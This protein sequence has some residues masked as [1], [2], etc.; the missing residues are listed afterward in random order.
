MTRFNAERGDYGEGDVEEL[1]AER[2]ALANKFEE[3]CFTRKMP[4]GRVL[5]IKGWPLIGGGFVSAHIDVTERHRMIENLRRKNEEAQKTARDLK[6]AQQAQE[7][8]Y[9]HLV[10]SINS[11]NNG[12]AIWDR[13]GF[14]VLANDAFRRFHSSIAGAIR[15][16]LQIEHMLRLGCEAKIWAVSGGKCEAWIEACLKFHRSTGSSEEELV[17]TDGTQLVVTSQHL[18]NG[19]VITTLIDVTAQRERER[20]L[21]RTKEAL[22]HIAYFDAL[23]TLPNRA[24]CQQDL[25]ALFANQ[26]DHDRFS[27]IL[28]DLDKFKRVNDTLG[29]AS[30]DELLKTLGSRLNFLGT[31]VP[32]FKPYRWGGDEF[33]AIVEGIHENELESLCQELTDLI[34]IPLTLEGPNPTTLWPTVS[35]GIASYPGDATDLEAL[36]IYADLALYKTKEMGRDGYQFFSAE[37]KEKIDEDSRIEVDVRSALKLDQFELY[38]QPQISTVD[39]SISGV[40]AL[41]RWNH[42]E[43]GQLPPGLFM[44]VVESHGMA[45]P[46]GRRVFDL[47][48]A[49]AKAWSDQGLDF[50]RLAINLSPGH[51]KKKTL[52]DDFCDSLDRHKVNPDLLAVELLESVLVND[53]DPEMN[54]LF[55]RIAASGVHIELDDFGTGYASLAHLSTLPVDGIKID[56]SFVN[57]ISSSEKQ[58]AIVEVVMSMSRLMQLRVVC[59]GIETHQQLSTVSQ[60]SNCSVQGYLVSRPLSFND[61]TQWIKDE[62]NIGLLTPKK[63]RRSTRSDKK[64]GFGAGDYY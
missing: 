29:H 21:N 60:I 13:D 42:P 59:E 18:D 17:L 34:A 24:Q 64:T 20:E 47:A 26:D 44:D 8:T 40:E 55:E 48:M 45:A 33:I 6:A 15:P 14:L 19:D 3:H 11:T 10:D 53:E 41:L 58:Q 5:E 57:N 61:M 32:Y 46:L 2:V 49:A 16:G 22:E 27:I 51:L 1:V 23:T 50:G 35:L 9:Q 7:Q 25:E 56:R 28:I 31:K 36:M 54:A 39:E 43:R 62:Q 12:F 63:V 37:M 4:D 30:G 38:F 52:I